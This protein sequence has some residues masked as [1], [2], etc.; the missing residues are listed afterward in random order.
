MG[1]VV[2]LNDEE[3]KHIFLDEK[4]FKAYTLD[5][6]GTGQWV[7]IADRE[8]WRSRFS[9]TRVTLLG[10]TKDFIVIAGG[11]NGGLSYILADVEYYNVEADRW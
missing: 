9:C 4:D 3:T 11:A 10:G 7:R 1:C 6:D 8:I 5:W 2:A